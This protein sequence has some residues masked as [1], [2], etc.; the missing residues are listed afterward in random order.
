MFVLEISVA[1]HRRDSTLLADS[2]TYQ[3][4]LGVFVNLLSGN[5]VGTHRSTNQAYMLW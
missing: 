3:A 4:L 1:T 5:T 2:R